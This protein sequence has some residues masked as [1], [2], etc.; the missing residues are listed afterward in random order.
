MLACPPTSTFS[1][2]VLPTETIKRDRQRERESAR[3]ERKKEKER[4]RESRER[5]ERE[6]RAWKNRQMVRSAV[7]SLEE[8]YSPET[9]EPQSIESLCATGC[10]GC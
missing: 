2:A 10:S 8:M 1:V 4:E 7:L 3:D 9:T 6:Q 5:A